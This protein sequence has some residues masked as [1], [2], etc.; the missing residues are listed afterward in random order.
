M[1]VRSEAVL[2]SGTSPE[3]R[4]QVVERWIAV[5]VPGQGGATAVSQELEATGSDEALPASTNVAVADTLDGV[6]DGETAEQDNRGDKDT[7][8][9]GE[10]RVSVMVPAAISD[11]SEAVTDQLPPHHSPASGRSGD[12]STL[13][14]PAS[15]ATLVC[16]LRDSASPAAEMCGSEP[17][18]AVQTVT[19]NDQ[20]AGVWVTMGDVHGEVK[21]PVPPEEEIE[22]EQPV[23]AKALAEIQ[24]AGVPAEAPGADGKPIVGEAMVV[25]A[26]SKSAEAEQTAEE[27]EGGD[28]APA[29]A[30]ITNPDGDDTAGPSGSAEGLKSGEA[31]PSF[32]VV[33]EQP[34]IETA[35]AVLEGPESKA[36]SAKRSWREFCRCSIHCSCQCVGGIS[37]TTCSTWFFRVK[38]LHTCVRQ[39]PSPAPTRGYTPG[40]VPIGVEQSSS[41]PTAHHLVAVTCLCKLIHLRGCTRTVLSPGLQPAV[42]PIEACFVG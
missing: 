41:S 24:S 13:P 39:Y 22:P 25:L 19:A 12:D 35:S 28:I 18:E 16:G 10:G 23:S 26:D 40:S 3:E 31:H 2:A 6:I 1:P 42:M 17:V 15:C 5:P 14:V 30:L 20:A 32:L 7:T 34:E 37:R 11:E 27:L 29:E 38:I 21:L 36:V 4:A 33:D 9:A 8:M